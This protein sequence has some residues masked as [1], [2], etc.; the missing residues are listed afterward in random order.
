MKTKSLISFSTRLEDAEKVT[1]ASLV[2]VGS[3]EGMPTSGG[4]DA[5]DAEAGG[6]FLDCPICFDAKH[7]DKGGLVNNAELRWDCADVGVDR[8]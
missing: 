5:Q 8:R 1:V 7:L 4:P 3:A 6:R 2:P